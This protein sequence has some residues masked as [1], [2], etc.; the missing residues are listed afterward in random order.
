MK[1]PSPDELILYYYG[2]SG[3]AVGKHIGECRECGAEFEQ[4]SRT[5]SSVA[6]PEAPPRGEEYGSEVW[7]RV[8]P[9]LPGRT[10]AAPRWAVP[11]RLAAAATVAVL[12]AAAFVAGRYTSRRRNPPAPAFEAGENARLPQKVLV[13]ALGDYLDRSEM[14]LVEVAHTDRPIDLGTERRYAG[15]LVATNRLYRQ[16]AERVGDAAA[17]A[18]L[19]QL[20]R[21]LLQLAHAPEGATPADIREL[22]QEIES[23]GLLFKVRV[24]QVRM[25]S[26]AQSLSRAGA[27][28]GFRPPEDQRPTL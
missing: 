1:H 17:D 8:R 28:K 27:R 24:A 16:T 25:R 2:E 5:L 14:L 10:R 23:G 11:R 21:V 3:A 7:T 18:L 13:V 12:L 6:C 9:R 22:R 15:E 19:D 26:E 20:E 4:L